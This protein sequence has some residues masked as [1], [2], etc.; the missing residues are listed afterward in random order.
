MIAWVL[1]TSPLL[2]A[3]VLGFSV[4]FADCAT[5]KGEQ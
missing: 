4:A 3:L 1:T 2:I 5:K